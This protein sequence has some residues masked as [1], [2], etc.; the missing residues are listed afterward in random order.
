MLCIPKKFFEYQFDKDSSFIIINSSILGLQFPRISLTHGTFFTSIKMGWKKR[1][2]MPDD[3][4]IWLNK[5][6]I[7]TAIRAIFTSF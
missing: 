1:W 3:V 5:Q 4:K 6:K 7:K 2:I